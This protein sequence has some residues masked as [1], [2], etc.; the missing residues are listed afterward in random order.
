M[1][2]PMGSLSQKLFRKPD[3]TP[4][5]GILIVIL[6][7]FLN[8]PMEVRSALFDLPETQHSDFEF[9]EGYI[10]LIIHITLRGE[11]A[12]DE[13][14][15]DNPNQL[16]LRLKEKVKGLQAE[17]KILLKVEK[18]VPFARV[19]EVLREIKKAG[20]DNI[21]LAADKIFP[22]PEKEKGEIHR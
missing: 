14:L 8:V 10:P 7:L 22:E 21:G 11:I 15:I 16:H 3:V 12:F 17:R 20:V 2:K 18:D 9:Y 5:C 4:F 19:Q 6:S 13:R 1:N